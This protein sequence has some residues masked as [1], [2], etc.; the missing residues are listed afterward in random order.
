MGVFILQNY[1]S[2]DLK[3]QWYKIQ[4][5][6]MVII[7]EGMSGPWPN[8]VYLLKTHSQM[9]RTQDHQCY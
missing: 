4:C 8:Y 1:E 5:E 9:N 3:Y 7:Y 6:F 2:I